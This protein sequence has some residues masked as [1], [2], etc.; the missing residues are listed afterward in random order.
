MLLKVIFVADSRGI[1]SSREIAAAWRRYLT[2]VALCGDTA[3]HFAT[4]AAFVSGLGAGAERLF[5]QVLWL[6]NRD[7]LVGRAM[8]A[9]DGV[10]LPSNASKRKSGKRTGFNRVRGDRSPTSS[11]A[12]TVAFPAYF[13]RHLP[14]DA[15]RRSHTDN[16]VL[17]REPDDEDDPQYQSE[18][19]NRLKPAPPHLRAPV[20]AEIDGLHGLP[21]APGP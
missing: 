18:T 6:R 8:F 12:M 19:R 14:R 4:L 13:I 21:P 1:V 7:G 5:A 15:S 20:D 3:P 10:K 16:C 17:G 9:I 2:F 11:D